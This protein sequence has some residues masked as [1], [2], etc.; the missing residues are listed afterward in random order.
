MQPGS[1]IL[2]GVTDKQ[3]AMILEFKTTHEGTFS[4]NLTQVRQSQLPGQPAILVYDNINF[5][6]PNDSGLK[7]LLQLL[8]TLAP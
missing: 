8:A 3:L 5:S 4:L 7:T 2:N 6:W 1:M